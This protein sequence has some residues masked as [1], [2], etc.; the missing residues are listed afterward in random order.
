MAEQRRWRPVVGF[1]GFYEVSDDG[2][3][4]SL[5]Y[6]RTGKAALLKTPPHASRQGY[7]RCLLRNGTTKASML[8][9]RMVAEAFLGP[10]PHPSKWTVNH[11]DG[12]KLN[13][14]LENLEWASPKDQVHHA[15]EVLGKHRRGEK[16]GMAKLTN[17]QAAE[18]AERGRSESRV[19]IAAEFGIASASVYGIMTGQRWS[20]VT[21]IDP[22]RIGKPGFAKLTPE[23]VGE[24]RRRRAAGERLAP[25]AADFGVSIPTASRAVAGKTWVAAQPDA[26][27]EPETKQRLL[28]WDCNAWKGSATIDYRAASRAEGEKYQPDDWAC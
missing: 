21:G 10:P 5:N 18:I 16:C 23:D 14:L 13:N 3:V 15:D 8:V 22:Y 2:L 12:D 17:E 28:C 24:M 1:E 27:I 20:S 9:H 25:I 4:M 26:P 11:K 6:R 7:M 19:A